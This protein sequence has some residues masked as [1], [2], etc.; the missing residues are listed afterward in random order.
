MLNLYVS[1]FVLLVLVGCANEA[2]GPTNPEAPAQEASVPNA[3]LSRELDPVVVSQMELSG[4]QPKGSSQK[5]F[6]A[7]LV[8]FAAQD[9]SKAESLLVEVTTKQPE[10]SGPWVNLGQVYIQRNQIEAAGTAYRKAIEVNA[11]NCA[12][13]TQ[14][15]VLSRQAGDFE[16]AE[17]YYTSCLKRIPGYKDALLNLGI[18]YDLY[19]GR[20]S[21]ALLAYQR[22]QEL[23]AEPSRRIAGWVVDLERRIRSQS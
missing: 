13:Y 2:T 9:F 4:A 7:A 18:L 19:L 17:Q 11:N 10:L 12:A 22:Y 23:E 5:L 20:L 3:V 6:D 8:A 15:G 16:S 21:E 1:A 14:L